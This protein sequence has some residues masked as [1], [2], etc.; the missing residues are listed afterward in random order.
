MSHNHAQ[1]DLHSAA[2]SIAAAL[3]TSPDESRAHLHAARVS[4]TDAL[5]LL[6]KKD[7]LTCDACGADHAVPTQYGEPLCPACMAKH[8]LAYSGSDHLRHLLQAAFKQWLA[9]WEAHPHVTRHASD[10]AGILAQQVME[11][12]QASQEGRA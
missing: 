1:K 4:V 10:E 8:A 3:I 6:T 2:A 5:D 11:D 9:T 7:T 12:L